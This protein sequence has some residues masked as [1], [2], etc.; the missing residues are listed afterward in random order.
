MILEEPGKEESTIATTTGD[1]YVNYYSEKPVDITA[2]I[3]GY[4]PRYAMDR[5]HGNVDFTYKKDNGNTLVTYSTDKPFHRIIIETT[6]GEIKIMK[7]ER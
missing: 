6:T 1:I 4:S 3:F 5:I 2:K 7:G